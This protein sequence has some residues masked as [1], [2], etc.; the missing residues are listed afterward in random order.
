KIAAPRVDCR[1]ERRDPGPH[2]R[3]VVIAVPREEGE[4]RFQPQRVVRDGRAVPRRAPRALALERGEDPARLL[5][6]REAPRDR[7]QVRARLEPRDR[8]GVAEGAPPLVPEEAARPLAE[9]RRLLARAERHEPLP[10]A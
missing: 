6:L 2:L 4:R 9:A 5:L 3:V 7:E 1:R 10:V 8:L